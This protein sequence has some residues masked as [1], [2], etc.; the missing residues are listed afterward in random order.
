MF[1]IEIYYATVNAN[2]NQKKTRA[3]RTGRIDNYRTLELQKY[4]ELIYT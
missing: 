2:V 1:N 4:K 3:T